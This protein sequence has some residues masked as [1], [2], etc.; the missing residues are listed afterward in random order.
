MFT[1][2]FDTSAVVH[3]YLPAEEHKTKRLRARVEYLVQ[4]RT[5]HRKAALLVPSFC[6]A[7]VFNT[8]AKLHF[9]PGENDRVLS[10]AEYKSCLTQFR[11]DI[12]WEKTF[13]SYDLS[14]NH[15]IAVDEIVPVEHK[16]ASN[17]EEK[18][19][20]TLDILVIAMACE[21]AYIGDPKMVY[22]ITCDRR[23]KKVF[24]ALKS[25]PESDLRRLKVERI[26]F[27]EPKHRRWVPPNVVLLQ[28]ARPKEFPRVDGQPLLNVW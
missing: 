8:F 7:E 6:I 5:L 9:R 15:I 23:M 3:L 22:L 18:H 17:E 14:R 1:H 4:Q 11:Q 13:Y 2:L 12:I 24:E 19:L 27:G 20:S 21:L 26:I 28:D 25:A 10:D 16:L